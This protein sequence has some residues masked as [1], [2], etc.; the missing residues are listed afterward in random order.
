MVSYEK[1]IS[2]FK[3]L[4]EETESPLFGS[5]SKEQLGE[6]QQLVGNKVSRF[7]EFYEKYQPQHDFPT[8]DC[9]LTLL[10]IDGILVENQN[11]EPGE[12]LAKYG[13]FVFATTAGGDV[14]CIDT[15]NCKDGDPAVLIASHNFCFYNEELGCVELADVPDAVSDAF[16]DADYIPLNYANIKKSLPKIESSFLKFMDKLSQ[17]KYEDIEEYLD[18]D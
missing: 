16:E 1:I 13:V 12:H 17:N 7:I 9:Y 14:V 15:N 5:S 11:G 18:F 2:N 4:L 3:K 8:L 6:L 10:D